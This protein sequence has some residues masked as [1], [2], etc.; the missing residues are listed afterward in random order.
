[1][2]KRIM[3]VLAVLAGT[4]GLAAGGSAIA[5]AQQSS[6]PPARS[7]EPVGGPDTDNIQSRDQTAP[8]AQPVAAHAAKTSGA[9]TAEA[10]GTEQSPAAEQAG[11]QPGTESAD[12]NDG[13]G[14]H[15]DEPGNANAD[16]QFEG[17]E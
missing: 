4:A 6:P 17:A 13:P 5:G 1:M 14:G 15:A 3:T 10:P 12:G 2:T 7:A 9:K 8:D 16:H 11:E